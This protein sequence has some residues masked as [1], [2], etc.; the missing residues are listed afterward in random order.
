MYFYLM[1]AEI[2]SGLCTLQTTMPSSS[3]TALAA[4]RALAAPAPS[5]FLTRAVHL[6]SPKY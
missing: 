2:P 5:S 1:L 3:C 4:R 6:A